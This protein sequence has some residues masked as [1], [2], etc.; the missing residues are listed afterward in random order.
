MSVITNP[1]SFTQYSVFLSKHP[2]VATY[3]L[4]ERRTP[5]ARISQSHQL[6][7][8]TS[9]SQH[10]IK[11]THTP[12]SERMH[13]S[14][15]YHIRPIMKL[16]MRHLL[17]KQP[18]NNSVNISESKTLDNKEPHRGP[19][20]LLRIPE[21]MNFKK[22]LECRSVMSSRGTNDMQAMFANVFSQNIRKMGKTVMRKLGGKHHAV[23]KKLSH[24][25][26]DHF[27]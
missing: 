18:P 17:C 3:R 21:L 26:V 25:R 27:F 23:I 22:E 16:S 10:Y 5:L 8:S 19:F 13:S 20:K 6:P 14:N 15:C 9:A 2:S 24:N 7:I 1:S 12:K 4:N 11:H